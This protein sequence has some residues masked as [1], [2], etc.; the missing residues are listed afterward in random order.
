MREDW[1]GL[2]GGGGD[3]GEDAVPES[4]DDSSD[5]SSDIE[6]ITGDGSGM[7]AGAIPETSLGGRTS[8][9]PENVRDVTDKCWE[10]TEAAE[11]YNG[12]YVP[13]SIAVVKRFFSK[14][15]NY[16]CWNKQFLDK[17]AQTAYSDP[18]MVFSWKWFMSAAWPI[19]ESFN[20]KEPVDWVVSSKYGSGTRVPTVTEVSC[21]TV[22]YG[23]GARTTVAAPVARFWDATTGSTPRPT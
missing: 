2:V 10:V 5:A 4:E 9:D 6:F 22:D 20:K 11:K 3:A 8:S 16:R 18:V 14:Y 21:A 7:Q 23:Y 15:D 17:G 13:C 19:Y 12:I 1:A